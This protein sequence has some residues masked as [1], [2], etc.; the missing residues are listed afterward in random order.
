M[1]DE[2]KYTTVSIPTPLFKKIEER[3]KGTGF[4]SVSSYVTYVLREII[5]EDE[6]SEEAFSKEDE[7]RVKERLRALGYLD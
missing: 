5:A 4:T 3:I 2:K 7:E 1:S 6:E